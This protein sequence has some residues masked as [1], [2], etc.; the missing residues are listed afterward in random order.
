MLFLDSLGVFCS[1]NHNEKPVSKRFSLD[2][3][4]RFETGSKE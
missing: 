1:G 4:G 3:M 2:K